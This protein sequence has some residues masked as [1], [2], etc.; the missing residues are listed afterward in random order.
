MDKEKLKQCAIALEQELKLH[1]DASKDVAALYRYEPLLQAIEN[2]KKEEIDTPI[3]LPLSYWYFETNIQAFEALADALSRFS[4]VL[5][6]WPLSSNG[7]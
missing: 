6:D 3:D 4:L 2:A 1:Q 5:K 7:R